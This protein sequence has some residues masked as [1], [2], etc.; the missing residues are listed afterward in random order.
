MTMLAQPNME[1]D[2]FSDYHRAV[3]IGRE[4]ER[5]QRNAKIMHCTGAIEDTSLCAFNRHNRTPGP[6]C[7]Q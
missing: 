3:P 4:S 5:G 7:L 1:K 6:D 2:L